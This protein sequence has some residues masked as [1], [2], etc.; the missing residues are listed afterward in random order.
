M[1]LSVV[2]SRPPIRDALG[3]DVTMSK[4][5]PKSAPKTGAKKPEPKTLL[6]E[7]LPAKKPVARRPP[8]KRP[9]AEKL[10]AKL[11]AAKQPA[12]KKSTA[13]KPVA[14]TEDGGGQCQTDEPERR[15]SK[16]GEDEKRRPQA[17][18]AAARPLPTPPR[19]ERPHSRP[20]ATP[21]ALCHALT[22][23][24]PLHEQAHESARSVVLARWL[25]L[26]VMILL[27]VARRCGLQ[28]L[29]CV[30]ISSPYALPR[31]RRRSL[32]LAALVLCMPI[33]RAAAGCERP[34][35]VWIA[36]NQARGAR[37]SAAAT[38][39]NPPPQANQSHPGHERGTTVQL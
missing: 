2:L 6:P 22:A 38:P 30:I 1:C 21:P 4:R 8:A 33:G 39:R 17:R 29:P 10:P 24:S 25:T 15:P 14:K 9:P 36:T 13:K 7:E 35:E 5:G 26:L 3:A 16:Q 31:R 28:R 20:A 11:P 19:I 12:T 23:S 18:N 34:L 37:V 32:F 27:S